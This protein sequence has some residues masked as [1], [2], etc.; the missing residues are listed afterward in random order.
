MLTAFPLIIQ[1]FHSD[2][3]SDYINKQVAKLL[4]KLLLE[5]TQSRARHKN[6]NALAESKNAAIVRKQFGYAHIPQK[7]A[8]LI[9]PFN[10]DTLNPHI[11]YHRPCFFPV[12]VVG[13]KE[14]YQKT[15][16]YSERQRPRMAN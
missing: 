10:K 5:F 1:S 8:P 14:K 2:N 3:G 15:Y 9:N 7:S 11:N 12:T 6:D 4:I 13:A 16:P